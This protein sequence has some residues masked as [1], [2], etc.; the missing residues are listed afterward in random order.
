MALFQEEKEKGLM[1]TLICIVLTTASVLNA[2]VIDERMPMDEIN[3]LLQALIAQ[4]PWP[5]NDS[6]ME[7]KFLK[8]D[9]FIQ[10]KGICAK[11]WSPILDSIH[12]VVGEDVG[13]IMLFTAFE[14]LDADNYMTALERLAGKFQRN[15]ITRPVMCA[16]FSSHGR[17]M[18]WFLADNYRN[19]RVRMLLNGLRPYFSD[20]A[21]MQTKIKDILS[22]RTKK[23][24]D[25]YR[26]A[27]KGLLD[28]PQVFLDEVSA[29]HTVISKHI[30]LYALIA[31]IP[32]LGAVAAWRYFRRR[33]K[34]K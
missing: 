24:W 19:A 15:E 14:D 18:R 30:A 17:R 33:R 3:L 4:H 26:K 16:A 27:H 1:K 29:V 25:D 7:G 21:S 28:T 34:W 8:S 20:D 9:E 6:V 32:V 10:L 12:S 11:N 22:G 5:P 2:D 31:S 13:K 23:D